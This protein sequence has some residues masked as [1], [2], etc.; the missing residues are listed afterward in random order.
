VLTP[1]LTLLERGALLTRPAKV[2]GQVFNLPKT[3]KKRQ[4]TNLPHVKIGLLS[5]AS[6]LV[7]TFAAH[8]ARRPSRSDRYEEEIA[9]KWTNCWILDK[10]STQIELLKLLNKSMKLNEIGALRI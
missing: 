6:L 3:R 10:H 8:Q 9:S 5:G 7:S 4:V 1:L 2:V